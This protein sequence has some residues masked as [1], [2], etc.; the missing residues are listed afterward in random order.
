MHV[1]IKAHEISPLR[2][3]E[4]S[5]GWNFVKGL[6]DHVK[7]TVVHA[8]TNQFG[9]VNYKEEIK[10]VKLN[11]DVDFIS[12]KQ[13]F[14][15]RLL[16]KLNLILSGNNQGTGISILYFFGVYFWELQV[17]QELKKIDLSN[18]DIIHNLNH[19]SYREPSFLWKLNKPF[20]WGP[21]SG[22]GDI[23]FAFTKSFSLK[24]RIIIFFRTVSNFFQTKFSKRII[25]ASKKASKIFY[26]SKEDEVFFKKLNNKIQY[27]PDVTID[28]PI[29]DKKQIHKFGKKINI[30]WV[31]R[32]DSIKSLDILLKVFKINPDLKDCFN[33]KIV[34][35]GLLKEKLKNFCKSN[36][37]NNI[38]WVG[39][40]DR[41]KVINEMLKSDLLIH[42]SIKEASATVIMEAL[43]C[44]LP[45]IC[46]DAFGMSKIINSKIGYKIPYF[47]KEK[48]IYHLNKILVDII[49]NPVL[50]FNKSKNIKKE[51]KKFTSKYIIK[52][53]LLSYEDIVNSL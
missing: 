51:A 44:Q 14:I 27:L 20:V 15:T 1:L 37:I 40:I 33:I 41:Q 10:T 53:I 49:K 2:G 4:C 3:S 38:N 29:F 12:V 30:I 26:V 50:L 13:P 35:N 42:T 18:I 16:S 45:V 28:N 48:S 11:K 32:I 31:G 39:Q 36:N 6:S 24:F 21:T 46:H 9:T 17:Y 43:S 34:G 23:P 25:L 8:E 5:N 19:V 52:E 7:L 47:S 22:I